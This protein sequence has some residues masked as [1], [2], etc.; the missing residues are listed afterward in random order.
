[1]TLYIPGIYI[2]IFIFLLLKFGAV[3]YGPRCSRRMGMQ[4]VLC[5]WVRCVRTLTY[6]MRVGSVALIC[7][8]VPVESPHHT[9]R[10]QR[11]LRRIR[12]NLEERSRTPLQ[13]KYARNRSAV[14]WVQK[15]LPERE[16]GGLS[17]GLPTYVLTLAAL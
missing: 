15:I 2:Y 1:M 4:L 7:M 5:R 17:L 16:R 11:C 12:M 8:C 10:A 14:V 13:A 3:H 9:S 6:D